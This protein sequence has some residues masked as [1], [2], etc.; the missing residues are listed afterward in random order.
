MLA[1]HVV[2]NIKEGVRLVQGKKNYVIIESF[3][4][5]TKRPLTVK[6]NDKFPANFPHF[7]K[8]SFLP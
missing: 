1:F 2:F 4:N 3:L 6:I 5:T 8:C 7:Y